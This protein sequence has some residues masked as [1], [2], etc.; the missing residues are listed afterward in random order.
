MC[1]AD[2]DIV[3]LLRLIENNAIIDFIIKE[4]LHFKKKTKKRYYLP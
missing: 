2:S 1:H 4:L 3:S